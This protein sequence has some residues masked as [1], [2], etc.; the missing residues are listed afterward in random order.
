[1]NKEVFIVSYIK[2]SNWISLNKI[3]NIFPTLISFGKYQR[4][5]IIKGNKTSKTFFPFKIS[6]HY[7]EVSYTEL[8]A[9]ISSFFLIPSLMRKIHEPEALF[10]FFFKLIPLNRILIDFLL[11]FSLYCIS[12][13]LWLGNFHRFI[14]N[15]QSFLLLLDQNGNWANILQIEISMTWTW[16]C[17]QFDVNS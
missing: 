13:L 3:Q 1:M 15:P 16:L 17:K 11:Q 5:F 12:T 2:L 8:I 9:F 6:S 14:V 7:L 4:E 10:N